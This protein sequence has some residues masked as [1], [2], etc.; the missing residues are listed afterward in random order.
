MPEPNGDPVQAV[1]FDV[2]GTLVD[3]RPSVGH[4]YAEV[5]ASNGC[6]GIEPEL[7]NSRFRSAWKAFPRQLHCAADWAELVDEVFLGLVDPLPSRSFF[8]RLYDRFAEAGAWQVHE[9]VI[10]AVQA[11]QRAG[12]RTAILSNWD[13][14]LRH[15]LQRLGLTPYFDPIIVSCEVGC[16]KPDPEIFRFAA[17]A[18]NLPLQQ[19]LHVG[20]DPVFDFEAARKA[21]CHALLIARS[22]PDAGWPHIPALTEIPRLLISPRADVSATSRTE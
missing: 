20:D 17:N 1:T 7:L 16:A 10:P 4:V 22:Q 5:A 15:L 11:L 14:R 19:I 12:I 13:E 18:L 2:G 9:D 6:P 8:P 21:Q 3:P